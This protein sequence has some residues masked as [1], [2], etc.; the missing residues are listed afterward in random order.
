MKP[1]RLS[2]VDPAGMGHVHRNVTAIENGTCVSS[3]HRC[4][5]AKPDVC[6]ITI[7]MRTSNTGRACHHHTNAP[8]Q[9]R[10]LACFHHNVASIQN[11]TL[12]MSSPQ[13]GAIQN[14]TLA[15]LHHNVVAPQ[16]PGCGSTAPEGRGAV[17]W[18]VDDS[19]PATPTGLNKMRHPHATRPD[20]SPGCNGGRACGDVDG[21]GHVGLVAPLQG[22]FSA[23]HGP[24]GSAPR[25]G[26]WG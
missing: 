20:S 8:I 22:A 19:A 4:G 14:R 10:T 6:V 25:L 1:A 2:V 13:R 21:W 17:P 24:Q 5:H 26:A 7:P 16:S 15:C 12:C 23:P 3:P 9:H 18:G 11:R